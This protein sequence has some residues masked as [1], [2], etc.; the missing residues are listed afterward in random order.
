MTFNILECLKIFEFMV[1]YP[2]GQRQAHASRLSCLHE[3]PLLR[4]SAERSEPRKIEDF[5]RSLPELKGQE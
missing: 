4:V 1:K 5:S 3:Q 2:K